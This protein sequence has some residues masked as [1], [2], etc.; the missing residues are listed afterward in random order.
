MGIKDNVA[1]GIAGVYMIYPPCYAMPCYI[2]LYSCYTT[3]GLALGFRVDI[4][5]FNRSA[6]Y[7]T[8]LHNVWGVLPL[9][10]V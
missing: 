1:L 3:M 8:S 6:I 7:S 4:A 9:L 2:M 10:E 5:V